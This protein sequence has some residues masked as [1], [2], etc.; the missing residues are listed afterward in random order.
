MIGLLG[1]YVAGAITLVVVLGWGAW[2]LARR[3][4]IGPRHPRRRLGER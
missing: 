3:W 1:A 4:A 2:M